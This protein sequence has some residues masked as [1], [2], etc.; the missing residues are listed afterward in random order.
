MYK[1]KLANGSCYEVYLY[2]PN[3]L[4][5]DENIFKV[6]DKIFINP[7]HIVEIIKIEERESV[8]SQLARNIKELPCPSPLL[9]LN[10][11]EEDVKRINEALKNKIESSRYAN[12]PKVNIPKF[13]K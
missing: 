1:I 8:E 12:L 10:L 4:F 5:R 9:N 13:M 3:D 7:Q 2:Q 6:S 11:S